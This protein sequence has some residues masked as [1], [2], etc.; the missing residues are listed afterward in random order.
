MTTRANSTS[1][2]TSRS[3]SSLRKSFPKYLLSDPKVDLIDPIAHWRS[4]WGSPYHSGCLGELRSLSLV[5]VSRIPLA[6]N[7]MR[8]YEI[9]YSNRSSSSLWPSVQDNID[10][11]I[12]ILP[13]TS[14]Y[15]FIYHLS[16]SQSQSLTLSIH[17]SIHPS[18]LP[19]FLPSIPLSIYRK[20]IERMRST[21]HT[22][23]ATNFGIHSFWRHNTTSTSTSSKIFSS[24]LPWVILS[25]TL[26]HGHS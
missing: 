3:T 12:H 14:I 24:T 23:E 2:S 6:T 5:L 26:R 11:Y 19:S 20:D 10:L 9:I 17:P 21:K 15:S 18:F 16:I 1:T 8:N 4:S 7:N 13:T 22:S 25:N